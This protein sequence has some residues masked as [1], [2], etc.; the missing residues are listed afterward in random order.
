MK[1]DELITDLLSNDRRAQEVAAALRGDRSAP[2]YARDDAKE[3]QRRGI[4]DEFL[5]QVEKR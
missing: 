5:T 1:D 4:A 3:L 2:A